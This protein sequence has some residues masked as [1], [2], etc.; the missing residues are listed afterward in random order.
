MIRVLFLQQQDRAT[1]I[2]LDQIFV[3]K[4]MSQPPPWCPSNYSE[5]FMT[6]QTIYFGR[7]TGIL[8]CNFLSYNAYCI[9]AGVTILGLQPRE[10][11]A[12]CQP[13]WQFFREVDCTFAATILFTLRLA[14]VVHEIFKFDFAKIWRLI[15]IEAKL[16]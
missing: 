6:V 13:A 10:K 4:A 7:Q 8:D 12:I 15:K 14:Q 9:P 2:I 11:V 16:S 3:F 5:M 1:L